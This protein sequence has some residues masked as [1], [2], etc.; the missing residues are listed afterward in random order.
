[1]RAVR[2][3]SRAT[4]RYTERGKLEAKPQGEVVRRE[5][6][7]SVGSLHALRATRSTGEGVSEVDCGMKSTRTASRM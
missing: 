7:A 3:S 1:M 2:V 5:R 6:L 4:R